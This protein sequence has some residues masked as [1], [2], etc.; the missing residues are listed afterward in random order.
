M[1]RYYAWSYTKS[2][3]DVRE[4]VRHDSS[5]VRAPSDQRHNYLEYMYRN[6]AYYCRNEVL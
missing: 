1:V 4:E 3:D 6:D 2:S 5:I